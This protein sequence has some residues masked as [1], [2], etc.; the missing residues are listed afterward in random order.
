M[1]VVV[2]TNIFP[3]PAEP[4]RGTFIASLVR[5]LPKDVTVTAVIVPLPWFPKWKPLARFP[6]LYL[7]ACIPNQ[8]EWEGIPVYCPKYFFLPKVMG[9]LQSLM[10][11][12]SIFPVLSR[13]KKE[14]Q[15]Q[16]INAHFIY[17]DGVAACWA[18]RQLHLPIVLSAR[19]TDINQYAYYRFRRPQI[20]F[21]LLKASQITAVSE[22]LTKQIIALGVPHTKV[23][24]IANGI[25][26]TAFYP[27]D[28]IACR[29]QLR[30]DP[31]L[32]HLLFVGRF[33]EEKNIATLIEAV[34]MLQDKNH[35]RFDL[36]LVGQGTLETEL[37]ERARSLK[38]P[39]WIHF[40]GARGHEE[41]P[42]WLGAAAAL[43]L[44][45]LREGMPNVVLEALASGRPVIA[46][47]VGGSVNLIKNE[48]N[49]YL[50]EPNTAA[51]L[52]RAI[53]MTLSQ[54]WDVATITAS[55]A[56]LTWPQ[57]GEAYHAVYR[58]ALQ[59]G[60]PQPFAPTRYIKQ[61]IFF[62]LSPWLIIKNG[63]RTG[64]CIALTFDDGPHP[65]FTP[66]VL[67][68]LKTHQAKATFFFVGDR[69]G[70]SPDI[71]HQ[72]KDEGHE[73][74]S[75][76]FEHQSLREK[77]Y[78]EVQ[79]EI[80]RA[81]SAMIPFQKPGDR[82]PLLRP[83]Y[84]DLGVGLLL[85]A[86]RHRR[87]IALWSRD[88]EDFHADN[89]QTLLEGFRENP[90]V[91]GDIVLLHDQSWVTVELLKNLLPQL[92]D[93]GFEMVTVTDLLGLQ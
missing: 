10:V 81:D 42:V 77:S 76:A 4:T 63:P 35:H 41:I 39:D 25:D 14:R 82:A 67:E 92:R 34:R 52:A 11:F 71:V 32:P 65:L 84:G 18:A 13:L 79:M 58:R 12:L 54:G 2:V 88:P 73:V 66:L 86:M 50:Y 87:R 93:E 16:I 24:H 19:G 83:P 59:K 31:T 17:P 57:T 47:K 45:S 8:W 78:T 51:E 85:W 36:H 40:Q 90:I 72:V 62:L 37:K 1:K 43:C 7:N 53:E 61:A 27:Q 26:H 33:S 48:K 6:R 56:H 68:Q 89:S 46:S 75:H 49:G 22:T 20:I 55:V 9:A 69:V 80:K 64:R 60:V 29:R 28:P 15:C 91:A 70:A 5:A 23:S 74:A 3:N 38:Y 30:L 44:P 21:A